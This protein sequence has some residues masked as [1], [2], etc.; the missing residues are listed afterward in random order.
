MAFS[1]MHRARRAA[2][3]ESDEVK[4]WE[5]SLREAEAQSHR[6]EVLFDRELFYAI[7]S[8]ER[9]EMMIEKYRAAIDTA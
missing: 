8:R 5:Q 7:Q 2:I 1:E 9:L 4:R 3:E 6:E